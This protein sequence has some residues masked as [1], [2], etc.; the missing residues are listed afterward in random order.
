MSGCYSS[1]RGSVLEHPISV[2]A[3]RD[4]GACKEFGSSD[5][6]AIVSCQ[7]VLG[8]VPGATNGAGALL[9]PMFFQSTTMQKL[10]IPGPSFI[11]F[12]GNLVLRVAGAQENR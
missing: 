11:S 8:A 3:D 9:R 4:T 7:A 1:L 6:S 5:Q 12:F 2:E 10:F